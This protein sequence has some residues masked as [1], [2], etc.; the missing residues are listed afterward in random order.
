MPT[1]PTAPTPDPTGLN[2]RQLAFANGVL[3]GK[4]ATQAYI[5]AGDECADPEAKAS[6]LASNGKVAEY[7]AANKTE[8][9]KAVKSHAI[10][11]KKRLFQ[12]ALA[13]SSAGEVAT[14]KGKAVTLMTPVQLKAADMVARME[15]MYEADNEQRAPA[16]TITVAAP[17]QPDLSDDPE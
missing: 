13:E 7:I 2:V 12:N 17:T 1:K 8:V 16:V 3:S 15:G 6:R 4:S 10:K 11:L 9:A 14:Y 5:D